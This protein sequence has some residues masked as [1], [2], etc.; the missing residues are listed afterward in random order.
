MYVRAMPVWEILLASPLEVST[1][2]TPI[3]QQRIPCWKH[4]YTWETC[5]SKHLKVNK[6]S[7]RWRQKGRGADMNKGCSLAAWSSWRSSF[8]EGRNPVMADTPF[9]QEERRDLMGTTLG[10]SNVS[11]GWTETWARIYSTGMQ[12]QLLGSWHFRWRNSHEARPSPPSHCL[13]SWN[14]PPPALGAR[15][16]SL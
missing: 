11:Y 2:W 6:W 3:T 9:S 7:K 15:L 4:R 5:V 8:R 12:L 13:V 14:T 1:I 16:P 10:V